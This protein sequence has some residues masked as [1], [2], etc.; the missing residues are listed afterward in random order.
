M[1]ARATVL[2]LRPSHRIA[3]AASYS[4]D[5]TPLD[6][7]C[8]RIGRSGVYLQVA[9]TYVVHTTDPI[10]NAALEAVRGISRALAHSR[11]CGA[12]S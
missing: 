6:P 9:A 8:R 3:S 4:Q 5:T 12:R 1:L 7:G 2:N 11:T 10:M